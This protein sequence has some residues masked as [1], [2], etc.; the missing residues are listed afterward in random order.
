MFFPFVFISAIVAII[1]HQP[2]NIFSHRKFQYHDYLK[3]RQSQATIWKKFK[4]INAT[5]N[6]KSSLTSKKPVN[7]R[8]TF[9]MAF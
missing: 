3:I 8:L 5:I 4:D 2:E 9:K 1:L 7:Y 6:L